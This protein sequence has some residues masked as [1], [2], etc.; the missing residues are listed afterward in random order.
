VRRLIVLLAVPILTAGAGLA[1]RPAPGAGAEVTTVTLASE[2]ADVARLK[3][4][5]EGFAD[6]VHASCLQTGV[7]HPLASSN[8][9]VHYI[10]RITAVDRDAPLRDV[11]WAETAICRMPGTPGLPRCF[12]SGGDA[13]L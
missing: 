11:S 5:T 1:L 6:S 7:D 8:D 12:S 3:L 10:C 13:L 9:L 2:V 4:V